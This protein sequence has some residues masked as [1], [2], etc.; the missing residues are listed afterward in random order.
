MR[1]IDA[2]DAAVAGALFEAELDAATSYNVHKDGAVVIR[3]APDVAPEVYQ[4][5]V[6]DLRSDPRITRVDA[7]QGGKSVCIL[8]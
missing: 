3:F 4:K 7:E 8:R 1:L 2:A 6:A 5:V